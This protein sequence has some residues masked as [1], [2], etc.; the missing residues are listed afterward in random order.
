MFIFLWLTCCSDPGE[1]PTLPIFHGYAIGGM[2]FPQDLHTAAP[3]CRRDA[4]RV[5]PRPVPDQNSII[6]LGIYLEKKNKT[7]LYWFFSH[8]SYFLCLCVCGVHLLTMADMT[9]TTLTGS[10]RP[11]GGI[12]L[13]SRMNRHASR[14]PS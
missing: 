14:I 12:S 7:S 5:V 4:V 1:D 10:P 6:I 9:L 8:L 13:F 11:D 2:V 3:A